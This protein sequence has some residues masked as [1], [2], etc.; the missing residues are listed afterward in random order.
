MSFHEKWGGAVGMVEITDFEVVSVVSNESKEITNP[1]YSMRVFP[2]PMSIS[3]TVEIYNQ[4]PEDQID[5]TIYNMMG[6][7]VV[8][9]V[10]ERQ[11][12]GY[13][14]VEWDASGLSSGF[15]YY[16]ITAGE[17][18]DVKKMIFLR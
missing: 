1:G 5:L 13:H 16:R 17:F 4:F 7:K 2:N 9:L 14:K 6:Q 3:T 18:V 15:Y 10:S 12:A 8:N 11:E